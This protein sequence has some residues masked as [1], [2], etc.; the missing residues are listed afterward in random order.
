MKLD[1]S[2]QQAEEVVSHQV[3][4][5]NFMVGISGRPLVRSTE[6]KLLIRSGVPHEHREA[7]W[8]G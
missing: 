4:W 5:E 1:I 3:K 7:I 6:L 8:K 2:F